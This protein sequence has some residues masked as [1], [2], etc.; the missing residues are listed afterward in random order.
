MSNF[1]SIFT[2]NEKV[3]PNLNALFE[4]KIEHKPKKSKKSTKLNETTDDSI[5]N[6]KDLPALDSLSEESS[7]EEELN[8]TEKKLKK[9]DPETERRTVFVGN[10]NTNSKKEVPIYITLFIF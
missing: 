1:E 10:L 5:E 7:D 9:L 4:R 6:S 2:K 8:T 3:D